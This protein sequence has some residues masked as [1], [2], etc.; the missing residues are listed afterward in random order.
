MGKLNYDA[1]ELSRIDFKKLFGKNKMVAYNLLKSQLDKKYANSSSI[2]D[3][4]YK[5]G[6]LVYDSKTGI[7]HL[8]P[9]ITKTNIERL[10]KYLKHHEYVRNSHN[11]PRFF[12]KDT[13]IEYI[14]QLFEVDAKIASGIFT[15]MKNAGLI[16]PVNVYSVVLAKLIKKNVICEEC[17]GKGYTEVECGG[18]FSGD[19][20]PRY[21]SYKCKKCDGKGN[22]P[23][24]EYH[25]LTEAEE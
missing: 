11:R 24:N 4:G 2:I 13:I 5:A 22:I 3:K 10:S 8:V 23:Q 1:T 21:E 14:Q 16:K 17:K 7:I 20:S 15:Q 19:G 25:F 6:I 18:H 9:E 12:D